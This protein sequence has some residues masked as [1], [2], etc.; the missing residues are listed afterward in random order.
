MNK[1]FGELDPVRM[2]KA[3]AKRLRWGG[4]HRSSSGYGGVD[5][6]AAQA[7][8]EEWFEGCDCPM[9][10]TIAPVQAGVVS[11]CTGKADG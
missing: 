10:L 3:S 5:D 1:A 2:T 6:T 7:A 11:R 8:P 4:R 9:W